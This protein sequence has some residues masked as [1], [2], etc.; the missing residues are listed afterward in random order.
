MQ[1]RRRSPPARLRH[2]LR[3]SRARL[4]PDKSHRSRR[5]RSVSVV[6]RRLRPGGGLTLTALTPLGRGHD[7]RYRTISITRMHARK[8]NGKEHGRSSIST[9]SPSADKLEHAQISVGTERRAADPSNG[10]GPSVW[11]PRGPSTRYWPARASPSP[12]PV[13][14]LPGRDLGGGGRC[15]LGRGRGGGA[16]G[17]RATKPRSVGRARA[18]SNRAD[19]LRPES[20][21]RCYGPHRRSTPFHSHIFTAIDSG[22]S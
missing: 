17:R 18:T 20:S 8:T 7:T 13:S 4:S 22:G 6:E 14:R 2:L 11:R 16:A 10:I 5:N 1:R 19:E 3:L 9:F 21:M 12:E 15:S